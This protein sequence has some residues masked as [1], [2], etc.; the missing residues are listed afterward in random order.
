MPK[1]LHD[2]GWL[3]KVWSGRRTGR[4][5]RRVIIGKKSHLMVKLS[6]QW[7]ANYVFEVTV[8]EKDHM[9]QKAIVVDQ[10]VMKGSIKKHAHSNRQDLRVDI[11]GVGSNIYYHRLLA[12]GLQNRFKT[13]AAFKEKLQSKGQYVDHGAHGYKRLHQGGLAFVIDWKHIS[14][15]PLKRNRGQSAHIASMYKAVETKVKAKAKCPNN[16]GAR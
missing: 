12:F 11:T 5:V 6:G 1:V 10:H 8:K 14:P 7:M 4:F 3:W 16:G 15:K 2:S 13:F 9:R